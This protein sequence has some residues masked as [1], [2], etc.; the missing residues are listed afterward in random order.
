[1]CNC[2]PG[3]KN[4]YEECEDHVPCDAG[5]MAL[6]EPQTTEQWRAAAFHWRDH[7]YLSGCSHGN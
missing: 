2:K 5:C 7:P 4:S 6:R 1:M 3:I